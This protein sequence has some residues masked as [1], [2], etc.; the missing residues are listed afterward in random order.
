MVPEVRP[1]REIATLEDLENAVALPEI[2][3]AN[4]VSLEFDHV[5]GRPAFAAPSELDELVGVPRTRVCVYRGPHDTI[6]LSLGDYRHIPS[7]CIS[8]NNGGAGSCSPIMF[9]LNLD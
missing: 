9:I 3:L 7:S 2:R 1:D 5:A 6:V 8:L 4:H